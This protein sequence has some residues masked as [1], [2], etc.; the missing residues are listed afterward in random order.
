V[1]KRA[2]Q[3]CSDQVLGT[4]ISENAF[5]GVGGGL[6]LDGRFRPVIEL[7]YPDFLWVAA[8]QIFNQIGKARHMFGG[9]GAVPLILRTKVAMGAGYGS[10][11]SMD[12]AGI[13]ATNPGWRIVAPST[14]A[15]YIGLLNTALALNDPVLVLEHQDLY[16]LRQLVPAGDLDYQLPFGK[17]VIRR[18]GTEV[19]VISYLSMVNHSIEAVE[20]TNVDA[21]IIDLRWLDQ[22]SIDWECIGASITKTN[23]VLIVEQGARGTSYGGWLS[24]EIQRRYFD[25]LDQPVERVTGSVASPSISRVLERAAFAKTEEIVSA[26]QRM[27]C[28]WGGA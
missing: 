16:G 14:A 28:G 3:T 17:A 23:N 1:T 2:L 26:L 6:A 12:P 9:E 21:E 4:P 11:H 19:T 25:W 24:D 5:A 7:M 8:D 18:E 10:Q 13:F 20:L 22:A 27:Q 15:D